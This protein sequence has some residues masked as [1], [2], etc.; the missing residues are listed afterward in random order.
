MTPAQIIVGVVMIAIGIF[1]AVCAAIKAE[2]PPYSWLAARA[3]LCWG[4]GKHYFLMTSGALV[5]LV[6]ILAIVG[7]FPIGQSKDG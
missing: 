3:E 7:V 2:F 1:M 6:G 5:A 4:E